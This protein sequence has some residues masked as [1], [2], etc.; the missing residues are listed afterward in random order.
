MGKSARWQNFECH[1]LNPTW[2]DLREGF[3]RSELNGLTVRER[4]RAETLLFERLRDAKEWSSELPW[5]V[6][7]AIH[8]DLRE[9]IPLLR[10]ML[11]SLPGKEPWSDVVL[12]GALYQFTSEPEYE[13]VI[14][15][16]AQDRDRDERSRTEA[17]DVFRG[18]ASDAA[19]GL[20]NDLRCAENQSVAMHA[21]LAYH[22]AVQA[23]PSRA[24]P[25]PGGENDPPLP[26]E[27]PV[28]PEDLGPPPVVRAVKRPWW[29]FWGKRW[30][31]K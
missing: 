31:L 30:E 5:W 26:S 1:V 17:I 16:I 10:Q 25:L 9:T 4:Q 23:D 18:R 29:K 15:A 20:F 14:L 13:S 3:P 2:E 27:P 11:E 19:L 24:L 7:G 28:P 22:A 12:M 6:E 21:S 8:L